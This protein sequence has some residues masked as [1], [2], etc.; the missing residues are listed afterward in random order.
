[1]DGAK[2]LAAI[3]GVT[4]LPLDVAEPASIASWADHVKAATDHVDV[5][6]PSVVIVAMPSAITLCISTAELRIVK[7][8]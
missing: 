7:V 4:V 1:M 6:Q 8:P 3:D 5:R 2:D